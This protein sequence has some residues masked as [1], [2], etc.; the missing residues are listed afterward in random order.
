MILDRYRLGQLRKSW[1][2]RTSSLPLPSDSV[3][4]VD[5]PL[6]RKKR[7]PIPTSVSQAERSENGT[8]TVRKKDGTELRTVRECRSAKTLAP[9]KDRSTIV[10]RLTGTVHARK[11]PAYQPQ[12]PPTCS[13]S[14][15]PGSVCLR[16]GW[17]CSRTAAGQCRGPAPPPPGQPRVVPE[18]A[19][20]VAQGDGVLKV[21]ARLCVCV[22]MCVCVCV[23][24][25]V[26]VWMNCVHVC[27][28][29]VIMIH[30]NHKRSL[31]QM[32]SVCG[33]N[34]S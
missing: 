13:S 7:S 23:C 9:L 29:A 32:H 21:P 17:S 12:V 20:R 27:S 16:P 15:A 22:C 2:F 31:A 19:H 8:K 6:I 24:V 1:R 26:R 10:E 30:N 33:M 3:V 18:E 14:A 25:C 4:A 34:L 11:Y 5:H 28:F